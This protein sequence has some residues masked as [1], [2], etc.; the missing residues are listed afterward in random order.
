MGRENH[1]CD[2]CMNGVHETSVRR[3]ISAMAL[4]HSFGQIDRRK[5]GRQDRNHLG[6]TLMMTLEH[7]H[8]AQDFN[9]IITDADLP[10][11]AAVTLL[12][13]VYGLEHDEALA[14]VEAWMYDGNT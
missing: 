9:R 10:P 2:G 11:F 1:F 8:V 3:R 12:M 4:G 14:S 7:R 5:D 6:E 13:E